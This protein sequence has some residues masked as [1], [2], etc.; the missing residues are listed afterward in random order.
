M[1]ETLMIHKN[2]IVFYDTSVRNAHKHYKLT[3]D[4][5][6]KIDFD[7][8]VRKRF[9]GLKKVTV[10]TINIYVKD[11][12]IPYECITLYED[13]EPGFRRYL[14]RIR[15]FVEDNKIPFEIH[16]IGN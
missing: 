10:E 14:G 16:R 7:N 2:E 8:A 4:N 3:P 11:E 15:D 1:E 5:I 13:T 12:E 9:F 6:T